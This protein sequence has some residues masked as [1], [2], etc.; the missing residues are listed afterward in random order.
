MDIESEIN[1]ALESGEATY[2]IEK[3]N[4]KLVL[5][6]R[7]ESDLIQFL[8]RLFGS[9]RLRQVPSAMLQGSDAIPSINIDGYLISP[10]VFKSE[11][12]VKDDDH[13][14]NFDYIAPK[15]T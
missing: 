8:D 4:K 10:S 15:N 12:V 14:Y 2:R 9:A 3:N 1:S 5:S 6:V 13:I 7:S 11:K